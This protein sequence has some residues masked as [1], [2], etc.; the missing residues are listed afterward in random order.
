MLKVEKNDTINGADIFSRL[1]VRAFNKF[2][3]SIG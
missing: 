1:L 2:K 3:G